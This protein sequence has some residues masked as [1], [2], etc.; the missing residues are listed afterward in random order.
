M[1]LTS[2]TRR[3]HDAAG[4]WEKRN[5]RI[6]NARKAARVYERFPHPVRLHVG[7]ATV[8]L[9]GWINTDYYDGVGEFAWDANDPYPLPAASCQF[10]YNEHF[11][12][13]L[14]RE[15]GARFLTDAYRL[16][17]PDGVLRV[18]T[19][20]LEEI[21]R[22]YGS[23]EWREQSWLKLPHNSG[24]ATPCEMVNTAMRA[25]GH[26]WIYDHEELHRYMETA[27]FRTIRY[28]RRGESEVPELRGLETREDSLLI[29]EAVR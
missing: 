21:A 19:P 27:G 28:C 23:S 8:L 10:I 13:H 29:C 7:C 25:W 5:A 3:L 22:Q 24:I 15:T 20:S 16:L 4:R 26:T 17:I 12:E 11:F 1:K 6:R 2:I 9:N 18:A 14:P